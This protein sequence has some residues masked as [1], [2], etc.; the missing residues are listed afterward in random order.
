MGALGA[1][2]ASL[3]AAIGGGVA[4]ALARS[5][6]GDIEDRIALDGGYATTAEIDDI[7]GKQFTANA[8]FG[9][10]LIAGA[11]GAVLW[12]HEELGLRASD[13]PAAAPPVTAPPEADT[14]GGVEADAER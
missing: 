12:F 7:E 8:M 2:G 6:Y 1:G 11:A 13:A 5:Q 10:A 9:V 4:G 14:D 3:L